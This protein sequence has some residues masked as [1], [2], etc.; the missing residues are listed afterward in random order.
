[1]HKSFVAGEAVTAA[2]LNTAVDYR[3]RLYNVPPTINST[4][5]SATYTHAYKELAALD[6]PTVVHI[7]SQAHGT[8]STS[9]SWMGYLG[10]DLTDPTSTGTALPATILQS[11]R[12]LN[13]S[14]SA[15]LAAGIN[16][17]AVFVQPANTAAWVRCL[18]ERTAGTWTPANLAGHELQVWQ[19][20]IAP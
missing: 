12:L 2:R 4:L 18:L 8:L 9:G 10:V 16:L 11:G 15:T 13:P 14:A 17:A 5:Q 1:M 6:Y 19:V 3:Q 20:E 7:Y